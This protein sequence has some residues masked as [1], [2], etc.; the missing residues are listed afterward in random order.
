MGSKI[1]LLDFTS[2]DAQK[3]ITTIR[4]ERLKIP[5]SS[6][7]PR[8]LHLLGEFVLKEAHTNILLE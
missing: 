6:P 8:E 1:I 7:T 4:Q 3:N 2:V 5:S